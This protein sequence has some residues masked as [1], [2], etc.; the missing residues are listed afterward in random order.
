MKARRGLALAALLLS[1]LL[2]PAPCA[3]GSAEPFVMGTTRPESDPT[4]RW[5]RKVY[6]ELFR[7]IDVP[8]RVLQ[9]PTARLPLMLEA[10]QIDGEMA[11]GAGYAQ[12][13]PSLVRVEEPSFETSFVLYASRDLHLREPP[14]LTAG[15]LRA[16]FPRGV[17]E[18]EQGLRAWLPPA[19][20]TDVPATEQALSMVALGRADVA[21]ALDMLALPLLKSPALRLGGLHPV[22][23]LGKPVPLYAFVHPRRADLAPAMAAALRQMRAEGVL[24]RLHAEL[25]KGE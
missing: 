22:L 23:S 14:D 25:L 11:R 1:A 17:M 21:C 24:E 6:A 15:D 7:R 16:V 13:H 9:E 18:C 12:E 5:M 10:G 8:L 4:G 19:R 3:A 2:P 20:V